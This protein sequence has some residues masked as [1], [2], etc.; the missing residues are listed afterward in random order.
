MGDVFLSR[1]IVWRMSPEVILAACDF[2]KSVNFS[3]SSNRWPKTDMRKI[4][5]F[6]FL[7]CKMFL[8]TEKRCQF[9]VF[10][11]I[12]VNPGRIEKR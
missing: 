9:V 2:F 6:I 4:F 1:S 8:R 11:S 7:S 5:D 10:G 3:L 12:L